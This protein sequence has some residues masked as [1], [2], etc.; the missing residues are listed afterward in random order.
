MTPDANDLCVFA[1]KRG[2]IVLKRIDVQGTYQ[3]IISQ[4]NF[5]FPVQKLGSLVKA[6]SG[7]TPSKN[8]TDQSFYWNGNIPWVSPKDFKS[9]YMVDTEDHIT[10]LAINESTTQVAPV[11]SVLV[12]VR[13]GIL[14]HTLPV[15]VNLVPVTINQDIKV[16]VPCESIIPDYLGFYLKVFEKKILNVCVKH[17]TTVQSINSK[18]FFD[19]DIPIPPA[20]KQQELVSFLHIALGEYQQALNTA[21]EILSNNSQIMLTRLNLRFAS[22]GYKSPYATI[23]K[24]L[25][26]RIDADYYSPDFAGFRK[27]IEQSPYNIVAIG[28]IAKTIITGFAAGKQDQADDLPDNQ[29]IPHLRPFSITPEGEL[30]FET[31]KYVPKANLKPEDYC[32]K[33]EILFNNTNSPELVGKTTVFDSD[34]VCAASNH[35]TRITVKDGIN[36]YYVAAFFNVLL[37]I[38]YWKLLCTNFNNQ[39]GVNTETLKK[40]RIPLPPKSIQDQIANE[41][42]QRRAQANQLRK[43][44]A[45]EWAEAKARF[46]KELLGEI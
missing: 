32:V 39:A 15:S 1:I 16:L 2:Y 22:S 34:V 24:N 20:L 45:K 3:R 33:N 9:F 8:G 43:Q 5:Q 18:E 23:L 14:K 28:N 37:S 42:M 6:Y 35:M 30:S 19:L 21:N 31:K 13:S 46:E 36:P 7:G 10:E 38:G 17:S 4:S 12:V 29:R 11:K 25:E 27:Q 44:A 26:E 40:V 41:I